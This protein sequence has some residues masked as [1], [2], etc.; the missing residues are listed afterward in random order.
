MATVTDR[1]RTLAPGLPDVVRLDV[2]VNDTVFVGVIE[3]VHYVFQYSDS[4]TNR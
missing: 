4:V 3:G 1:D 2:S